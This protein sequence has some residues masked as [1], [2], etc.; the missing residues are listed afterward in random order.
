MSLTASDIVDIT[1]FYLEDYDPN[2][3]YDAARTYTN[4]IFATEIF[5]M[6]G[7]VKDSPRSEQ[8]TWN[9]K[10]K[11]TGNTRAT[12]MFKKD[13][14][15]NRINLG[16]KGSDKWAFM[17]TH[18]AFDLREPVFGGS[19]RTEILDY[20]KMHAVDMWDGLYESIEEW[21]WSLAAAPNDGSD[22]DKILNG[23][24]RFLVPPASTQDFGFT[25]LNPSGYSD[26]AGFDR[27][28]SANA[29]LRNGGFRYTSVDDA[30]R[31]LTDA[32]NKCR[33]KSP[34]K[35]A[36]AAGERQ[37]GTNYALYSSYKPWIDYQTSLY[38]F[39]DNI[40]P[41]RGKYRGKVSNEL[42]VQYYRGVPWYWVDALTN[43]DSPARN[44][45]EPIYGIN[46]DTWEFKKYGDWW[47]KVNPEKTVVD[48]H[49]VVVTWVDN[50]GQLYCKSFRE[51]FVG[52][53]HTAS[54][55]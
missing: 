51:N 27:T 8:V 41:D 26:V 35:G 6:S 20:T 49:N 32:L 40:G 46:W 11:M 55:A 50:G 9:L 38:D 17:D 16:N 34:Y 1:K 43:T 10:T 29:K 3:W 14:P 21:G 5:A 52:V 24:P 48:S 18:M 36:A 25:G 15:I 2:G 42:G 23:I 44:T 19:S 37:I 47:M 53:S 39:N 33:F 4:Y 22:G 7:K 12:S 28:S 45:S 54:D 30:E 31:K 13:P